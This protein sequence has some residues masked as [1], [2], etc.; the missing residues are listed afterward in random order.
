MTNPGPVPAYVLW[1]GPTGLTV[2]RALGREGV[3]VV[4]CHDDPNEPCVGTRY[5]RVCILPRLEDDSDAWLTFLLDEA[6][7]FA[8]AKATLF[9]ASDAHWLFVAKHRRQLEAHFLFALPESPDILE[10]PTKPWQHAAARRAGIAMP[11]SFSPRTVDELRR[12]ARAM[13]YPCVIKPALSMH[14]LR[15]YSSKLAFVR[16]ED[17]LLAIAG[18]ATSK[19]LAYS[20]QEYI[21]GDDAEI[22]G[23][24]CA[25]DRESR[26]LG[27]CVSRKVR[28]FEPRFGSASVSET[29]HDANVVALGLRFL[30]SIRFS[31]IASVEFK[32]DPRDGEYK[33]IEANLRPPLMMAD[34]MDSGVNLPFVLYRDLIGD[35][36]PVQ[37][38]KRVGRRVGLIGK[39]FQSARFLRSVNMLTWRRWVCQWCRTRD[40]H[41]AFDDLKPFTG[42]LHMLI[43]HVRTGRF[44]HLPDSF[45]SVEQWR[46]GDLDPQTAYSLTSPLS[47]GAHES[48]RNIA[49]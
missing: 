27:M 19:R 9:V 34:A 21:P 8:P 39:D 41:F 30:C 24:Y 29:V 40:L 25:L 6:K 45:V 18:D 11:R 49:A 28:Q 35:P 33:F 23:L 31:G 7:A 14:W 47:A 38:P 43:D 16:D 26:P 22:C 17:E 13:Q 46:A 36:L 10:W 32:R 48:E 3:P 2:V 1:L 5:A 37:L 12:A 4:A 20:L 42:Y 44:R 15:H